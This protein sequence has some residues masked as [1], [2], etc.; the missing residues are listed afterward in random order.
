MKRAF[1]STLLPQFI[2]LL[3]ILIDLIR[4]SNGNNLNCVKTATR[5]FYLIGHMCNSID[6]V[7]NFVS[8]GANSIEVDIQFTEDGLLDMIYHGIPCDCFRCEAVFIF[9]FFK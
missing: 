8:S 2:Y 9:L 1:N 3:F 7:R 6:E 4:L 5:P